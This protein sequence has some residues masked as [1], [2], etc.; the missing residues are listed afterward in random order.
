MVRPP[1]LVHQ[2]P[3]D[4][5]PR[6]GEQRLAL[7]TGLGEVGRRQ[8]G[9]GRLAGLRHLPRHRLRRPHADGEPLAERPE[10][11]RPGHVDS[12]RRGRLRPLGVPV[13][14]L[15]RNILA[16]PPGIQRPEHLLVVPAGRHLRRAGLDSSSRFA[17]LLGTLFGVRLF[18]R[19]PLTAF[20]QD[21]GSRFEGG[22]SG[23]RPSLAFRQPVSRARLFPDSASK[24]GVCESSRSPPE[25]P[26]DRDGR[27][28]RARLI[29]AET[30]TTIRLAL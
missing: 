4:L 3:G 30:P 9:L 20:R 28:C 21:A 5:D 14:R 24:S 12:E 13:H 17:R 22:V 6:D 25:L 27:Y 15:R 23:P 16:T 26:R 7:V 8:R 29:T 19:K 2:Q 10:G 11:R 18:P 1:R